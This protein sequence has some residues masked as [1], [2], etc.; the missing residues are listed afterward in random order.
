MSVYESKG[1]VVRLAPGQ[2]EQVRVTLIST[3]E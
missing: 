3:K 1:P 2:T